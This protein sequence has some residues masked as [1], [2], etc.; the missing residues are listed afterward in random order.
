MIDVSDWPAVLR[1]ILLGTPFLIMMTGIAMTLHIAASRHFGVMCR[2]FGRSSGMDEEI[3]AWGT[4]TLKS[5]VFIVAA[6]STAAVWP[7]LGIRRGWLDPT[8]AREFPAYLGRRMRVAISC[9]YIGLCW[10]LTMYLFRFV[11]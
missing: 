4:N 7:S 9:V 5:R 8:D 2:A 1:L 6:M 10:L 11:A 3:R